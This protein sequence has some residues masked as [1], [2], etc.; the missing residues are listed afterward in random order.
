V[1]TPLIGLEV[2]CLAVGQPGQWRHVTSILD[3]L[4]FNVLAS[5]SGLIL[6]VLTVQLHVCA[7]NLTVVLLPLFRLVAP[8]S[9][10]HCSVLEQGGKD[11]HK[12]GDQV[13]VDGLDVGDAWQGGTY[14]CAYGGHG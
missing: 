2:K 9:V 11:E 14:A 4:Q 12:A 13:D 1:D 5:R 10:V 8:V 7:E 6:T 3:Y